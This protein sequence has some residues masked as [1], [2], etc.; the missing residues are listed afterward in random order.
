MR[1]HC[2]VALIL[3]IVLSSVAASFGGDYTPSTAIVPQSGIAAPHES[4]TKTELIE[5]ER[6]TVARS[7]R[8]TVHESAAIKQGHGVP[9]TVA[10]GPQPQPPAHE[11]SQATEDDTSREK[12]RAFLIMILMLKEGR[13]ARY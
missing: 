13:G 4:D 8:V 10:L 5:L 12:T 2:R 1:V 11:K 7:G 6:V 9:L 3:A